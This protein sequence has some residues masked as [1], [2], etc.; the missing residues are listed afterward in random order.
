MALD[1]RE[2][3][4]NGIP[5]VGTGLDPSYL[6]AMRLGSGFLPMGVEGPDHRAMQRNFIVVPAPA[7]VGYAP[8]AQIT[9]NGPQGPGGCSELG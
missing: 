3:S 8:S 1:G 2:A 9:G 4:A 5:D 7:E 6:V